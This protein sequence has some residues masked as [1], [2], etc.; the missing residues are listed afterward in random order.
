MIK[1]I[2]YLLFKVYKKNFFSVVIS[3]L[4]FF[5]S[6]ENIWELE[7]NLDCLDFIVEFEE[8][9]KKKD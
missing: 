7:V 3:Y 6:L 5:F 9:K 2:F 4:L 8:K 1:N